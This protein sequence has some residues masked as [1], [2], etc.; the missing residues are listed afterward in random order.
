MGHL[1]N[2]GS[3]CV[4]RADTINIHA[5][6]SP[7]GS[8]GSRQVHD[9]SLG[10]IVGHLILWTIDDRSRHRGRIDDLAL[11]L[12]Q[13]DTPLSLATEKHSSQI[14]IND[15]SPVFFGHLLCVSPATDTCV[16]YANIELAPGGHHRIDHML[17]LL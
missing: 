3:T 11:A 16:V 13:H 10:G 9:P 14:Q 17:N 8:Q 7:L 1:I 2:Q 5:T 15:I 6:G 12:F 4:T